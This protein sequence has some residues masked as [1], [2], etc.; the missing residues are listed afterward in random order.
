MAP[1]VISMLKIGFKYEFSR[2]IFTSILNIGFKYEFFRNIVTSVLK[3]GFKYENFLETLSNTNKRRRQREISCEFIRFC[4]F[5]LQMPW[6]RHATHH[7]Y[8]SGHAIEWL[9]KI[10]TKCKHILSTH[11]FGHPRFHQIELICPKNRLSLW[12]S[13]D[14][15]QW[16]KCSH[17]A[18]FRPLCRL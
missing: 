6:S 12:I 8:I 1:I 11:Q 18:P 15:C 5:R 10:C 3:I 16:I 4:Q 13:C 7:R 14:L 17:C 9:Y 2:N